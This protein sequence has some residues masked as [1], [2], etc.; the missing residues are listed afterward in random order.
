MNYGINGLHGILDAGNLI[1]AEALKQGTDP[2]FATSAV[3]IFVMLGGFITNLSI[4][5]I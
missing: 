3:F 5:L 2:M 1:Q 4:A